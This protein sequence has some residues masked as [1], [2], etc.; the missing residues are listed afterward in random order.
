M[1]AC[2]LISIGLAFACAAC[3][4]APMAETPEP[5]FGPFGNKAD[6]LRVMDHLKPEHYEKT[7]DVGFNTLIDW[8]GFY[9]D[10]EKD[11]PK[12][13]FERRAAA[14]NARVERCRKDGVGYVELLVLHPEPALCKRF[15][16]TRRD[17]SKFEKN[18]EASDPEY[19]K[20]VCRAARAQ[21]ESGPKDNPAYLGLQPSSE[22]RDWCEPSFSEK[23]RAAYRAYSGREIPADCGGRMPKRMVGT[24]GFP[25][26]GIVPLD[27]P[28]LDFYRWHWK[29]GDGWNDYQT[30]LAKVFEEA[31]G[32]PLLSI[33]DPSLRT[34]PMWESGGKVGF[35]QHWTYVYPEPY[36]VAYNV[37]EQQSRARRDGQGVI[38]LVQTICYRRHLAPIGKD[39]PNPPRWAK[40]HPNT[41]FPTI[42][43]DLLHEAL[44]SVAMR[45]ADGIGTHA[46]WVLFDRP[47]D[48]FDP[49]DSGYLCT[50][51]GAEKV[52]KDFF[53]GVGIPLGPLLRAVPERDPEVAVFESYAS[54]ILG[55][56]ITWDC[57][58]GFFTC[59]IVATAANLMPYALHEDEVVDNGIPPSVKVL[60]MPECDA[61]VR[62]AYERIAAF[63]KRGG[64]IVGDRHLVKALEADAQ[65]PVVRDAFA[66]MDSDHDEDVKGD[67][68]AQAVRR[69]REMRAGVKALRAAVAPA[70][71]P[72]ADADVAD[73]LVHVRSYKTSDYVFAINDRRTFGD[74]MGQWKRVMEKGV[75][76][77]GNVVVNRSA[78]AVYDLVRH[79]AVPFASKEGR[80]QIPVSYETTGGRLLL[81][82]DRPLREL[83]VRVCGSRISVSSPDRDVMIPIRIDGVGDK[84]FY[85]VVKDG[86]YGHDFGVS[87][88]AEKVGVVNLADGRP[89]SSF[90]R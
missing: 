69:D 47:Y 68:G 5:A 20:A 70:V 34:P 67:L 13:D 62:P 89:V 60:L 28:F 54:Q 15:P 55:S 58:T 27:E 48:G 12:P 33:Y 40:D 86:R 25:A 10:F 87:L 71:T 53:D 16:R 9:W 78:G 74:Y 31:Y 44:W 77:A 82:V 32:R 39:P 52:F 2:K 42:P 66:E 35:L 23:A 59:G 3:S 24:P 7:V 83:A 6:Q 80:T 36:N 29:F 64:R 11:A 56:R 37:S 4:E 38:A 88:S 49:K 90:S 41:K 21:A 46:S 26:D 17:G 30:Q 85:A 50:H 76:N 22:V 43:P 18:S 75:S 45:R 61:L 84:P 79:R 51:S 19:M 57:Q 8:N 14:R 65:L 72:Y 1:K 63:V 73:I 81:V